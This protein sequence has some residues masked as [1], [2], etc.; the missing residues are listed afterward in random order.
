MTIYDDA[1]AVVQ[2]FTANPCTI[3]SVPAVV[4]FQTSYN[5]SAMPGQL[6]IDGEYGGNTQAALQNVI[7]TG[8]V[9][10]TSGP[11]QTAPT[12]CFGMAVPAVPALDVAPDAAALASG[13]VAPLPGAQLPPPPIPKAVITPTKPPPNYIPWIVGGLLAGGTVGILYASHIYR[14]Q[15]RR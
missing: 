5:A 4:T 15:R 6:S 9:T 1:A 3:S 13:G 2:Y 7:N 11:T 8:F 10:G 12:N 14:K